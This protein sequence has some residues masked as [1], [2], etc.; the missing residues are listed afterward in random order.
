MDAATLCG[1]LARRGAVLRYEPLEDALRISAGFHPG[2]HKE[3]QTN[4]ASVAAFVVE[5]GRGE[6]RVY[7]LDGEYLEPYAT[8]TERIRGVLARGLDSPEEV[9]FYAG[10][11]L[12]VAKSTLTKLRNAGELPVTT[13]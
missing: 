11:D 6:G 8:A 9:A 3:I 12:Q 13:S 2:W 1:M 7:V 5:H 10:V 4:R